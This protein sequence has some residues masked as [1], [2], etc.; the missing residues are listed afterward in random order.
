MKI[1]TLLESIYKWCKGQ[2]FVIS[3][4]NIS[5]TFW[6][7]YT[8]FISW[9]NDI[10]VNRKTDMCTNILFKTHIRKWIFNTLIGHVSTCNLNHLSWRERKA[11]ILPSLLKIKLEMEKSNPV[12]F[13]AVF[14]F[15]LIPRF[16]TYPSSYLTTYNIVIR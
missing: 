15:T 1:K 5:S 12:H 2:T 10:H 6:N 7:I 11:F 9:P 14:H 16:P 3:S 13:T 8:L 4:F